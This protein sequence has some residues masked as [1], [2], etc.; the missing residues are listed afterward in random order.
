QLPPAFFAA[1]PRYRDF[2]FAVFKLAPAEKKGLLGLFGAGPA[3][4]RSHPMALTFPPR[5]PASLFFPTVHVHDGEVHD[6]AGFD[7]ALFCQ[8]DAFMA[9]TLGWDRNGTPL[10]EHV[11]GARVAGLVDVAAGAQRRILMGSLRNDDVV[12]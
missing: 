12:L 10:A 3:R 4:Q 1:L 6:T 8:P 11:D 9:A 2:G 7:H 5:D